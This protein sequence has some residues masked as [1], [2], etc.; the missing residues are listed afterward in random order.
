MASK[1]QCTKVLGSILLAILLGGFIGFFTGCND[2]EDGIFKGGCGRLKDVQVLIV[3]YKLRQNKCN[4]NNKD[5]SQCWVGDGIGKYGNN[6]TCTISGSRQSRDKDKARRNV[7][8]KF[9]IDKEYDVFKVKGSDKCET[10]GDSL[11]TWVSGVVL[12]SFGG[13]L[14]TV[15][16]PCACY[17]DAQMIDPK[18]HPTSSQITGNLHAQQ[19][20]QAPAAA[21]IELQSVVK[22]IESLF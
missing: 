17:F 15:C 6:H 11:S 16:L 8:K 5:H 18:V 13:C 12:L 10:K 20:V 2:S 4:S 22:D 19:V 21:Q 7:K 14:L 9:K 3:G 1:Y